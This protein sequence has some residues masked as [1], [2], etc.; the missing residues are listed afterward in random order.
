MEQ[1]SEGVFLLW[2]AVIHRFAILINATHISHIDGGRIVALHPIA[3]LF[4]SEKLM[5]ASVRCD[6]IVITGIAPSLTAKLSL[7]VVDGL[8]L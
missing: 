1:E 8:L 6:Y 4:N 7:E 2:R 3:H 5:S